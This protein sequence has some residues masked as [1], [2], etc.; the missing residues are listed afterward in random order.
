[1]Q[2]GQW[3]SAYLRLHGQAALKRLENPFVYHVLRDELYEIDEGGLKFL[4][5]CDG[6]RTG[7]ELAPDPTFV[8]YCI[9]EGLLET[10]TRP[11]R[12][13]I[14]LNEPVSPSLRYLELQLLHKCNLKC[15]HC[16]LG[17]LHQEH[18]PLDDALRIAREFSSMGGLRLLIS[19]GEP[20][21][22][23]RARDVSRRDSG[24]G[25]A[26]GPI[27]QRHPH[28]PSKHRPAQG[29]GDPVQPRRLG[30]GARHDPR[31]RCLRADHE[32]DSD[33]P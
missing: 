6:T 25:T 8:E 17:P 11:E 5:A 22:Y 24:L 15:L 27:V 26:K 31:G 3:R 18:L 2:T 20:L 19:G 32:G 29:G 21:L 28:H 1:M 16:Y 14:P 7:D 33:R 10:L 9:A 12:V 23:R 30:P 4:A 13:T